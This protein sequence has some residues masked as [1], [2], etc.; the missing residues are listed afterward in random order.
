MATEVTALNNRLANEAYRRQADTTRNFEGMPM[1]MFTNENGLSTL[2][3]QAFVRYGEPETHARYDY[4]DYL[5]NIC[6]TQFD[7]N[8][9]EIW[10][11][12]LPLAADTTTATGNT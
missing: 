7:D 1:K 3:S 9:N 12:V 8:G 10:G 2:V 11:T 4:Q 5:G 6:V